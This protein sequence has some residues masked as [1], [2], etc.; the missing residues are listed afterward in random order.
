M[1]KKIL[2]EC[3]KDLRASSSTSEHEYCKNLSLR[4]L[5]SMLEF[6]VKRKSPV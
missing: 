2:L 1:E 5:S 4:F 6:E 3:L